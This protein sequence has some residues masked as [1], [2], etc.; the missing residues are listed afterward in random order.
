MLLG[1]SAFLFWGFTLCWLWQLA[2]LKSKRKKQLNLK[3]RPKLKAK[4]VD[5]ARKTHLL[6]HKESKQKTNPKQ[7]CA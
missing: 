2:L 4:D 5:V 1:I 3:Q 7:C 6:Q